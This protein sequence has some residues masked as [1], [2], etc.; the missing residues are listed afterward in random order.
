MK[1]V[2]ITLDLKSFF[3]GALTLSGLLLL[4]NSRPADQPKAEADPVNRRFQ[5]VAGERQTVIL[6]TQ[7]GRF[8]IDENSIRP[9]WV[10]GDFETLQ[11]VEKK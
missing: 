6:D 7:T 11:N 1:P 8:L 4:T 2:T 9:R 5:V 3:L 10:K